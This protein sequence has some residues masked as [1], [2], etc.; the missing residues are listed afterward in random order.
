MT[1]TLKRVIDSGG[2]GELVI[3]HAWVGTFDFLVCESAWKY[4]IF[5]EGELL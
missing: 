5:A 2:W 3:I 4:F 1:V